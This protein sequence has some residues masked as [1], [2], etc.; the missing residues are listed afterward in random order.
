[1][2]APQMGNTSRSSYAKFGNFE[3]KHGQIKKLGLNIFLIFL[4]K[5]NFF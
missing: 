5:I 2:W 3:S 1:M 4:K